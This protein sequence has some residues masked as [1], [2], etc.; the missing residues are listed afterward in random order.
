MEIPFYLYILRKIAFGLAVGFGI[1]YIFLY[2]RP[3]VERWTGIK[4]IDDVWFWY[5]IAGA[6]TIGLLAFLII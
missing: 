5:V 1:Y 2:G 4:F 3:I 6:V